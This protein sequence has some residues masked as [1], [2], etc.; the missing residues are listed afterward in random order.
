MSSILAYASL[1]TIFRQKNV[2]RFYAASVY[3]LVA[4]AHE[5]AFKDVDGPQYYGIAAMADLLIMILTSQISRMPKMVINL[6]RLCLVSIIG[7]G[8]GWVMWYSYMPPNLYNYFF[9]ALYI[10]AII[11]LCERDHAGVDEFRADSWFNSIFGLTR[12]G[13]GYSLKGSKEI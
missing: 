9:V 6:H 4:M 12:S 11:I 1:L 8:I 2:A 7:N 3:L 10:W 5:L 13:C